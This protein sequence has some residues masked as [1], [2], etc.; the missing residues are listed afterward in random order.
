MTACSCGRRPTYRRFGLQSS[1]LFLQGH[2][3]VQCLACVMPHDITL[4]GAIKGLHSLIWCT[5]SPAKF[6]IVTALLKYIYKTTFYVLSTEMDTHSKRPIYIYIYI[7]IYTSYPYAAGW[8]LS[9]I[10]SLG[11]VGGRPRRR[12]VIKLYLR[13][14]SIPHASYFCSDEN[15]RK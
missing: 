10:A 1:G 4:Y 6:L 14:T 5:I 7:Y 2:F 12:H 11:G 8:I 9:S 13:Y 15:V 3:L